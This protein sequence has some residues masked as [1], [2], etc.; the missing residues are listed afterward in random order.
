M[1]FGPAPFQRPAINDGPALKRQP[2]WLA[3]ALTRLEQ[4]AAADNTEVTR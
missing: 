3:G 4:C 2:G 1:A